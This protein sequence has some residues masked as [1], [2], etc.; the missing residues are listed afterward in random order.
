MKDWLGREENT[1]QVGFDTEQFFDVIGLTSPILID[2]TIVRFYGELYS[3][4]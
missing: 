4:K 3:I 2:N 1:R